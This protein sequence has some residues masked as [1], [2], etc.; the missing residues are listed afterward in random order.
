MSLDKLIHDVNSK[1]S[2]LKDA[3]KL[4]PG[5]SAAEREELL[6]LMVQQARALSEALA[7]FE[8]AK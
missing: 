1:C 5:S 2:S 6:A 3:A 8:R 4:L 7:A